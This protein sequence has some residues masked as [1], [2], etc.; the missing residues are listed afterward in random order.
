M[1]YYKN[2]LFF[3]MIAIALPKIAMAGDTYD[4]EY[5]RDW[6]SERSKNPTTISS[7]MCTKSNDGTSLAIYFGRAN[8]CS[9]GYPAIIYPGINAN[10]TGIGKTAGVLKIDDGEFIDIMY[11]MMVIDGAFF[12]AVE[13]AD[14]RDVFK[15][16]VDG[17]M[18][19]FRFYVKD[20]GTRSLNYSLIGF[21]AAYKR[22]QNLCRG[23]S[24]PKQ[25]PQKKDKDFFEG[26]TGMQNKKDKSDDASYF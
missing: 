17:R 22:A 16:A 6:F 13:G 19:Q 10:N 7:Y 20:K 26:G 5:H 23:I 1:Y 21:T 25:K 4:R 2:I 24:T 11:S 18:V 12:I 15:D 14:G 9:I 3:L 8:N